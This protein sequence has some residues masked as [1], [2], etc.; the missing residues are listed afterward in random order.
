[1]IYFIQIPV[2]HLVSY[3]VGGILFGSLGGTFNKGVDIHLHEWLELSG[4]LPSVGWL[5]LKYL[6]PLEVWF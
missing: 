1:M 5:E 2:T 3:V 6:S 4:L